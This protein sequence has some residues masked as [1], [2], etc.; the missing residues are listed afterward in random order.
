MTF[1]CFPSLR[2][3]YQ[4]SNKQKIKNEQQINNET[5][6]YLCVSPQYELAT[7]AVLTLDLRLWRFECRCE[8]IEPQPL[9]F[10]IAGTTMMTSSSNNKDPLSVS[11]RGTEIPVTWS[12]SVTR[13]QAVLG[14]DSRPFVTWLQRCQNGTGNTSK[15]LV[16]HSI[17]I[18]SIDM[19]GPR[20]VASLLSIH[21]IH[22]Y[23][24]FW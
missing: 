2:I 21:N 19:F 22:L 10:I 13:D 20:Y 5:E 23:H 12:A 9:Q 14:L 24:S 11:F 18:Q 3:L 8:L 1:F 6:K 7:W 15:E 4:T 16:V 17:E